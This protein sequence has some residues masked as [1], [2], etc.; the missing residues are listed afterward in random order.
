MA[1]QFGHPYATPTLTL[2]LRN[3]EL[4]NSEQLDLKTQFKITMD[5]EINS[6]RRT[7]MNQKLLLSWVNLTKAKIE[8]FITFLETSAG[9]EVRYTDHDANV[10]RGY[11]LTNPL[12]YVTE[13]KIV[14]GNC[15]EV[16]TANL[17]FQGYQP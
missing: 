16:Y 2:D 7:P 14:W 10:W 9:D 8:E 1:V 3:P 11:I 4:G 12:D 15:I 6:H 5:G 13:T 17:E